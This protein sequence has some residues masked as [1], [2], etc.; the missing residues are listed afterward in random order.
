M[1]LNPPPPPAPPTASTYHSKTTIIH[2]QSAEVTYQRFVGNGTL[3]T[4]KEKFK[5]PGPLD[6][7]NT[8]G[9]LHFVLVFYVVTFLLSL[10]MLGW[11]CAMAIDKD[12]CTGDSK[13]GYVTRTSQLL[14]VPTASAA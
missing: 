14:R 7:K 1:P 11:V 9:F 4:G 10:V 13:C 6:L 8:T 2:W 3:I 12:D 5:L